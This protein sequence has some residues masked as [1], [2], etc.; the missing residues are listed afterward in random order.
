MLKHLKFSGI[1]RDENLSVEVTL[2]NPSNYGLEATNLVF[3]VA[4]RGKDSE[5]ISPSLEDMTFFVMD[6]ADRLHT[7]QCIPTPVVEVDLA[8]D[9]PDYRPD[10]LVYTYF[11][12]GFLFQDLRIAFDFQHYERLCIIELRH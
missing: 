4:A 10:G 1:F 9:E 11:E 7:A 12:H 5:G 8:D 2:E 3:S 6:E